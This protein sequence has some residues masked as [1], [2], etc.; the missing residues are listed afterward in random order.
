MNLQIDPKDPQVDALVKTVTRAI[1]QRMF[2]EN[3]AVVESQI[4]ESLFLE[5][6]E[7]G[8][9]G[10]GEARLVPRSWELDS[11]F[12]FE[13]IVYP[14]YKVS[15]GHRIDL[16]LIY[17]IQAGQTVLV[18]VECDGH[19]F[20]EKTKQQAARDKKRDRDL[21]KLGWR[22]LRFTG[23]EIHRDAKGCCDEI[24]AVLKTAFEE[25]ARE[26]FR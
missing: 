12:P 1:N 22:V 13:L 15:T 9:W 3:F 11:Y 2:D 6:L 10:M 20:H 18:A 7:Y 19:D 23:S 8:G 24:D 4:E 14:Q 17:K 5:I 26:F 25:V 21:Q 16:A